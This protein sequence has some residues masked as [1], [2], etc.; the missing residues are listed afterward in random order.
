MR[1]RMLELLRE[2]RGL[3]QTA[4][5]KASSVPQ[6]TIS[7]AENGLVELDA[8]RAERIA[9]AL[10]YPLDAFTWDDEIFGLGSANFHHR[11]QQSLPVTT[12]QRIHADVN[13]HRMRVVRLLNSVEI[14]PRYAIP[15]VDVDELGSPAE[16]ARAVR[17]AWNLPMGPIDNMVVALERAGALVTHADL[18]SSKISALSQS[19]PGCPA[20]LVL[21]HGMSADRDRFTL[22]HEL[23]HLVMHTMPTAEADAERE[24]D[25][26]ASE[27]LMPAREIRG[28]LNGLDLAGAARL[29]PYWKTAMSALIRRA[30]DLGCIDDGRYKSL[31]VQISQRGWRKNEPVQI[32]REAPS[33]LR[34]V[35]DL[36]H[37][38]HGYGVGE[39]AAVVGLHAKEYADRFDD[40]QRRSRRL[41]LVP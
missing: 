3:S 21:N 24:A 27:F 10:Q 40:D 33:T 37:D 26:F 41:R 11:K 1:P 39:L 35:I 22:A 9:H 6:P 32:E 20:L 25:E 4:L 31:N 7:K 8:D 36:H 16:V 28:Q 18:Y 15:S 34:K 14:E 19:V 13:L 5:A 38:E 2:S 12:L 30:R 17:A 29:K 23:G